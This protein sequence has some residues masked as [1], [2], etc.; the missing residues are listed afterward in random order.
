MEMTI[1]HNRL[2]GIVEDIGNRLS[3]LEGI[4]EDISN[5]LSRL[6]GIVEQMDRRL[7]H[8]ESMSLWTLGILITTWLTLMLSIWVKK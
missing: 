7:S 6:E 8:L 5:R 1:E 3:R 4:V 2:R